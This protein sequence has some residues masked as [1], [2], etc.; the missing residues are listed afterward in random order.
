MTIKDLLVKKRK[1]NQGRGSTLLEGLELFSRARWVRWI[2]AGISQVDD[3]PRLEAFYRR[4]G[5][6]VVKGIPS[7][8]FIWTALKEL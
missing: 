8:P 2:E 5:Y 1:R 6:R 4:R 3:M 7:G